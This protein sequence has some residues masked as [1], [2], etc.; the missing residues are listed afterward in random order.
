MEGKDVQALIDKMLA[1]GVK[2]PSP[3][4]IAVRILNA[5]QQEEPSLNELAKIISSDPALTAKMLQVANSSFYSLKYKVT[6]IE[7]ALT[8]LGINILQNIALSFVIAKEMRGPADQGFDFDYFWRRSVTAAVAAELLA[9]QLDFRSDDT[10]VTALLT[11]IGVLILHQALPDE[12]LRV[13]EDKKLSGDP[14]S[15]VETRLLGITHAE[16]GAGLLECWKLPGAICLPIRYHHEP[17]KAPEEHRKEAEILQFADQ[18]S[19]IYYD[20]NCGEKVRQIQ[21]KL[22]EHFGLTEEQIMQLVDSVANR[23]I[24]LLATFEID[25]GDLKPYSQMLEEANEE[26]GRLN[27]SYEQLVM[28]LKGAKEET[29]RL[30]AELR[31]ANSKLR[32]LVFR[33]GLTG[34][35][36]HR[37]FQEM[38]EREMDRAK[39]YNT[40]FSLIM[41]DLD[42]FKKVNDNYGHPNGDLV[43]MNVAHVVQ[44]IAR[45]SDIVARYGGEEFAVI[46]PETD[47]AGLKIFAERLRCSIERTATL[48]ERKEIQ[49]TISVG[50]TCYQATNNK[51]GK[52]KIIDTAD[53]ALYTSKD[54]GRNCVTILPLET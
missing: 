53:R 25:P 22:T 49:V 10:F 16:M 37:Y 40:S 45:P 30:A 29:D 13:F 39:R 23:S 2:L 41:F 8:V 4:A 42:Y 7:K 43:L 28:E 46:L 33:D 18:L 5:V 3:P 47:E 31:E 14:V 32:E 44:R 21:V 15:R 26:L 27:L 54:S 9:N 11:D 50:G 19:A 52:K 35:Y 12:Y 34:L 6:S 48:V 24:E 51:L 36:N 17:D 1:S 20:P 38:V